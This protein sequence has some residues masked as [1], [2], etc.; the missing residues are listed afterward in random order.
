VWRR[1][2]TLLER[3]LRDERGLGALHIEVATLLLDELAAA[4]DGDA[5]RALNLLES[6]SDLAVPAGGGMRIDTEVVAAVVAGGYRRFDKQGDLFYEQISALHKSVRG[7]D[8]DAA[9]YWFARMLDGGCDPRYVA[10]RLVRM[11]SEDIGN[12]DPRA[13]HLALDAAEVYERLG[14]PEESSRWRRRSFF[15]PVRRS[16]MQST[17]RSIA[18]RDDARRHGTLDVPMHLRNAP[19]PLMRGLGYGKEYRYDHDEAA[20]TRK[21][22]STF[23]TEWARRST[24]NRARAGWRSGSRNGW[25]I[26]EGEALVRTRVRRCNAAT[27]R[28]A[29]RYP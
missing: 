20:R 24:T 6:A 8:P 18:P 10:R 26:E 13:L 4:A 21:G 15:S 17:S 9:L 19:T 23:R 29:F 27:A 1:S 28:A 16:R 5:R 25:R 7:S 2:G 22:S 14:S 12:A 11:A 3:A